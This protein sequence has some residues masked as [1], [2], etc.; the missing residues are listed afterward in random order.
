[1]T[2]QVVP[3]WVW[4]ERAARAH[5]A[6]VR[7]QEVGAPA[8]TCPEGPPA[9]LPETQTPSLFDHQE[10]GTTIE[11]E[12]VA[13][14]SLSRTPVEPPERPALLLPA[15]TEIAAL[16]P[17]SP[18]WYR[19]LSASKIAAV[20]GTSPY[21]SPY[22][23][24]AKMTGK[25]APEPQTDAMARGHYLEPAVAAWF[26]DQHPE[27]QIVDCGTFLHHA[28]R[29]FA[30]S[31]DRLA[32]KPDG[33]TDLVQIKS[34]TKSYEWG[35]PGTDEVPPDYRDQVLWEMECYGTARTHL[36]VI[37]PYLEFA[38][39]V[40]DYDP[41]RVAQLIAKATEFLALVDTDTAPSAD[42]HGATYD[43]MRSVVSEV[44]P[45]QT[46]E[47]DYHLAHR[48]VSATIG[49]KAAEA[50]HTGARS[51]L[52]KAMGTAKV[53]TF[54]GA[55]IADRRPSRPGATPSLYAARKLPEIAPPP[56]AD[57]VEKLAQPHAQEA[58]DRGHHAIDLRAPADPAR[59]EWVRNRVRA[60]A[61]CA[62]PAAR[63][64]LADNW[65]A[66]V[67]RKADEWTAV[68]LDRLHD[69]LHAVEVLDDVPFPPADPT[70]VDDDPAPDLPATI[71]SPLDGDLV[72]D[73]GPA[74]DAAIAELVALVPT[75]DDAQIRRAAWWERQGRTH[76]RPWSMSGDGTTAR[77]AAINA[78][79]LACAIHLD[80]DAT[81][82]A[83]AYATGWDLQPIWPTGALLG[84]LADGEAD[85]LHSFAE[86]IGEGGPYIVAELGERLAAT[87]SNPNQQQQEQQ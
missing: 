11:F 40:V 78:A 17:G 36:A 45:D 32:I 18:E 61:G 16:T 63:A 85:D 59:V 55:K 28:E 3:T 14:P 39:Y 43:A 53:A 29:R 4:A 6:I 66:G 86:A 21:D 42:S 62:N 27:W 76:G 73:S 77:I 60:V 37:G 57:L 24:W 38:E 25:L 15:G 65:P 82:C 33:I 19:N 84:S 87:F 64:A 79:A 41:E 58:I 51:A 26:G 35:Q 5:A 22:S 69:L 20:M 44:D 31:P 9:T 72:D 80:D 2:E 48:F 10:V 52:L 56:P 81:R 49:Y 1:M 70:A 30:A 68:D 67:A 7:L 54:D 12:T 13:L 83:I 23:L 47:L 74:A 46:V 71:A 8:M 50:E 75:L 34:T